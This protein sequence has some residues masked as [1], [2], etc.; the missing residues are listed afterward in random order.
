MNKDVIRALQVIFF[1]AAIAISGGYIIIHLLTPS[2]DDYI[3]IECMACRGEGAL[4]YVLEL[5]TQIQFR[6]ICNNCEGTGKVYLR[7]DRFLEE[8]SE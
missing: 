1:S 7:K 2:P 5:D 8:P 6:L 3:G 4:S